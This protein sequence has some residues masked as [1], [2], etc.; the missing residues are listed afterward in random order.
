[1]NICTWHEIG[2]VHSICVCMDKLIPSEEVHERVLRVQIGESRL[3]V[4]VQHVS[5]H[6]HFTYFSAL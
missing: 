4:M 6:P 5:V 1:M 3:A 2:A